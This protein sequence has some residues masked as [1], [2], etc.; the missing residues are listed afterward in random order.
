MEGLR[1]DAG[2][3]QLCLCRDYI[4]EPFDRQL[5][6]A[7]NGSTTAFLAPS[8]QAVADAYAAGISERGICCGP[9]G[10]RPHYGNGY[11]G[12][13]L[14]DQDGNKIHIVHRGD[15]IDTSAI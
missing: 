4:Y 12:A 3:T 1:R 2:L 13:Y 6:S 11:F 5:A 9:P 8:R 10:P 15:L 7:G 14:Y